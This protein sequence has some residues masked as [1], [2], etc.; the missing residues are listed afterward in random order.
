M[1]PATHAILKH[2][3]STLEQPCHKD[4]ARG[5][6]SWCSYNRDKAKGENT[7]KPI[8]DP[9]PEAIVKVVQPVFDRLGSEQFLVGSENCLIQNRNEGWHHV[10]WSMAP[11]E[12]YN[13]EQEVSIAVSLSVL[14]FNNGTD[15]A[16]SKVFPPMNM[17]TNESMHHK[18]REIDGER[19]RSP[20]YKSNVLVKNQRKRL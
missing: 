11:K 1:S 17:E 19:V 15:N 3:S 2:Y 9:L 8:Q 4:W 14:V 16:M 20:D 13:S 6:E 10:V 7:H 18:L 5:R 12:Q